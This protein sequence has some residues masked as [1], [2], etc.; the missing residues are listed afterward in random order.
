LSKEDFE[1][2]L[3]TSVPQTVLKLMPYRLYSPWKRG[4]IDVLTLQ[5][6]GHTDNFPKGKHNTVDE[7]LAPC[8]FLKAKDLLSSGP[9]RAFERFQV[10]ALSTV[11]LQFTTKQR[12]QIINIGEIQTILARH[13]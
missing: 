2:S 6:P 1:L 9:H 8:Y 5:P 11:R 10:S 3:A 12:R 7:R 4:S 13:W